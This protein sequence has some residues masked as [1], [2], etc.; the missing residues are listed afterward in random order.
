MDQTPAADIRIFDATSRLGRARYF[1]YPM[2]V[3]LMMLPVCM[4][5]GIVAALFKSMV[6]AYLCIALLYIFIIT[7]VVVFMVRRLHD[8]D[9][10][11]WW[12]LIYGVVLVLSF[13]SGLKS[14]SGIWTVVYAI[15]A[16]CG[17]TYG[18]TLLF[19]PGTRGD[20]HFGPPPPPNSTAIIVGAWIM[21]VLLVLCVFIVAAVA[22][23]AYQDFLARA[24][25][26]ET[27]LLAQGGKE[28]VMQYYVDKDA[29]PAK[30]Q[31][32]YDA[33][34]KSPAGRYTQSLESRSSADGISIIAT[35]KQDGVRPQLA[36][37]SIEVWTTD[38]AGTWQCGPGG[39]DPVDPRYLPG[40]C[41]DEGAP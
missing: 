20:N 33:A 19:W 29:W 37:K 36:G 31:D 13:I 8:L 6:V 14:F 5:I 35:F 4:V 17:L 39:P 41:R 38:N 25:A 24:Q 28:A 9:R 1:V 10:S 34:A 22:V 11:G 3:A 26:T 23:P 21:G 2:L 27:V 40:N 12:T 30:L 18:L 32:A 7:M 16:L 15:C